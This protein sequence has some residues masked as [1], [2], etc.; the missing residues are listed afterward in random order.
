[1]LTD[2]EIQP[3][4]TGW[5]ITARHDGIKWHLWAGFRW[6]VEGLQ[7]YT[8]GRAYCEEGYYPSLWLSNDIRNAARRAIC[9]QN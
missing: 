9:S 6:T 1:M 4:G 7:P 5:L 2:V 3:D 8:R